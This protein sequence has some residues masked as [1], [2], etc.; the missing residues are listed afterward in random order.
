VA[1]IIFGTIP[2]G[3]E[4]W[5]RLEG[6]L[7]FPVRHAGVLCLLGLGTLLVPRVLAAARSTSPRAL[8]GL[9]LAA[10]GYTASL[11]LVELTPAEKTHFLSYGLLAYLVYRAL[12]LDL[13]A[14]WTAPVTVGLMGLLGLADEI[15]QYFVPTRIFEWKD[16]FLNALSGLLAVILVRSLTPG[17]PRRP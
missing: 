7:G 17:P 2:F 13:R 14:A 11:A 15:I 1:G 12:L 5:S 4:L 10:L 8:A 6:L 3:P 9:L 16:V